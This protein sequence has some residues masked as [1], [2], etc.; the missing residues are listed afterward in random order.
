MPYRSEPEDD[1]THEQ[2]SAIYCVQ[3]HCVQIH[4]VQIH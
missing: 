3:I 4:C 2:S 1:V